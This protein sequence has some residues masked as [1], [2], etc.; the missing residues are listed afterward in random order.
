MTI[1]QNLELCSNVFVILYWVNHKYLPSE[2]VYF[3]T[4]SCVDYYFVC[5]NKIEQQTSVMPVWS[6]IWIHLLKKKKQ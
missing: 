2:K 6:L 5:V 1:E 3:Y 4:F